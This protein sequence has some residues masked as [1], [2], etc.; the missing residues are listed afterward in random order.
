MGFVGRSGNLGFRMS[1]S[2]TGN[3]EKYSGQ[4]LA[5]ALPY[6]AE[7]SFEDA[8]VLRPLNGPCKAGWQTFPCATKG[9]N[10]EATLWLPGAIL[11]PRQQSC[12]AGLRGPR[13][14]HPPERR[15]RDSRPRARSCLN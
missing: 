1:K 2:Q 5:F 6:T 9:L 4:L 7:A 3:T 10:G 12:D 15:K 11:Q 8:V 14:N 13:D